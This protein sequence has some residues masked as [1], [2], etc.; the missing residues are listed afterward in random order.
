MVEVARIYSKLIGGEL[1]A[2]EARRLLSGL[3]LPG[4]L[5]D[6]YA[7]GRPGAQPAVLN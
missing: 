3:D 6:G 1:A 7:H 2:E 4:T 5:V